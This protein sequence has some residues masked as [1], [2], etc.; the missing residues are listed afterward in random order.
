MSHPGTPPWRIIMGLIIGSWMLVGHLPSRRSPPN[1]ERGARA[2]N[3][4]V[5][6]Y[7]RLRTLTTYLHQVYKV[8]NGLIRARDLLCLMCEDRI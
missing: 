6:D 3:S 7:C 5:S 8:G 4:H 1:P 2:T